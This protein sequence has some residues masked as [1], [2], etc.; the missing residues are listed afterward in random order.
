MMGYEAMRKM[1]PSPSRLSM[2]RMRRRLAK[3]RLSLFG[4]RTVQ[5]S[6]L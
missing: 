5:L 4:Y 3:M 1:R 6:D 2:R